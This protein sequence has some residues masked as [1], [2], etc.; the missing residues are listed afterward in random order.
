MVLWLIKHGGNVAFTLPR[1][2]ENKFHTRIKELVSYN[3]MCV[4]MYDVLRVVLQTQSI[5]RKSIPFNVLLA[6]VI[7]VYQ[8]VSWNTT[9]RIFTQEV[10]RAS[11]L[12]WMGPIAMR[13]NPVHLFITGHFRRSHTHAFWQIVLDNNNRHSCCVP[14]GHAADTHD[15]IMKAVVTFIAS[16]LHKAISF[17][18][19]KIMFICGLQDFTI[20]LS[21]RE[22]T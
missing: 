14:Q 5:W 17:L 3:F 10:H 2:V 4:N 1:S 22:M 8:C 18:C 19:E 20:T 13:R 9:S 11:C 12:K 15:L 6:D 16:S 7:Q 21:W